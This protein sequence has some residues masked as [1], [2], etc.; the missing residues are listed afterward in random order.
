VLAADVLALCE[1]TGT[2][3]WMMLAGPHGEFE[4]VAAA[5]AGDAAGIERDLARAGLHPFRLGTARIREGITL[6]LP[7]GRRR[8]IDM[9]AVRN[10]LETAG[11][12]TDDYV[13]RFRDLGRTWGLE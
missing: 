2:P 9:A 4:L 1:R 3:P 13:A 6:A 8:D 12:D 10:L 7:G 11:G 5:R